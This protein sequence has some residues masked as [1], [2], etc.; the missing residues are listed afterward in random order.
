MVRVR[1]RV[2]LAFSGGPCHRKFDAVVTCFFL[3]VLDT[4]HVL[5]T[6]HSLLEE[7]Y[8]QP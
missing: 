8:P 4:I 2:K 6:V 7:V 5:E 3:D 1:V